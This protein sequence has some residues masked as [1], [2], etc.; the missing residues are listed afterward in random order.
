MT[1]AAILAAIPHRPPFL[2]IDSILDHTPGEYA[3]SQRRIAEDDP[4]FVGHFPD[5][6]VYP[7]V[8]IVENMAQTACFALA[9]DT[10]GSTAGPY[11]LARIN[12]STFMRKVVPGETLVT[13]AR[14]VRRFERMAE[15]ACVCKVGDS[16]V[17]KAEML[18][19]FNVPAEPTHRQEAS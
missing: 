4:V 1:D 19:T 3:R 6:P 7:G 5:D 8:L 14:I 15:F 18:V 11:L 16:T 12:Q 2:M 13:E 10:S 17:A 9:S